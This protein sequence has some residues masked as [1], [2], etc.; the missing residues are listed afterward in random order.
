MRG[1]CKRTIVVKLSQRLVHGGVYKG[2]VRKW[3][4]CT[5]EE[6]D[7]FRNSRVL[8]GDP[9]FILMVDRGE[10]TFANKVLPQRRRRG[11]KGGGARRF[12]VARSRTQTCLHGFVDQHGGSES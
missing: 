3:T 6:E 8:Q 7:A 9:P 4:L 12:M 1:P 11:R 2:T 10:C 5:S